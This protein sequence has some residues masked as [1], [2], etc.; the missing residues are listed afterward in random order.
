MIWWILVLIA[1]GASYFPAVKLLV[2]EQPYSD[3]IIIS[4]LTLNLLLLLGVVGALSP[5]ITK[6]IWPKAPRWAFVITAAILGMAM[7]FILK[8]LGMNTRV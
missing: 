2:I 4:N 6:K 5:K 3:K 8:L 7:V 1:T